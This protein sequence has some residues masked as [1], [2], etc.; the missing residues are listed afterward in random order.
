[1]R[2]F[3]AFLV[4]SLT[5]VRAVV[6]SGVE[7]LLVILRTSPSRPAPSAFLR[8]GFGDTTPAGASLLGALVT[9][10]PGTTTIDVDLERRELLLHVLD[11]HDPE[12]VVASIRADFERHVLVLFPGASGGPPPGEGGAS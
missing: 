4:L 11:A 2:R 10:T 3:S 6:V 8:M 9:L 5:F 7:T 12:A 1:M